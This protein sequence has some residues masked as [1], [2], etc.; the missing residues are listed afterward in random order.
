MQYKNLD[1]CIENKLGES[2]QVKANFE[3][4]EADGAFT[5]SPD[6][7]KVA[8]EL[9]NIEELEEGSDLPMSLGASL[10]QCLFRERVGEMLFMSLGNV[11]GGG[12]KEKDEDKEKGLRIRLMLSPPEVAALPWEVLYDQRRK[13]FLSTSGKTPLSRY[14]K[15]FEPIRALKI[16]PPVKVLILIPGGSGLDVDKEEG[17]ITEAL[18]DL[19][20]VQMRVIKDKVTRSEISRALVEEEYHILH[21]IGHGKFESDQ[22]YLAINGQTKQHDLVTADAFADFFRDYPSMKLVVLNACQGAEV[23]ATKELAGVAPQL[24]ARGIPAVVAMQYPIS[25]E[26]ALTF[27]REFYL[28][29]CHGSNR[30]QVDLA[31]S[32]ARNQIHMNIK[33]PLAFATPVLFLRSDAGVI[34][35]F[36]QN[37]RLWRRLLMLF[38]SA[39]VKN[40]GRLNEVKKTY[41]KNIAAWQEKAKDGSPEAL[42]EAAQAVA[43]ERAELVAI[44]DRIIRWQRTFFAS[45][46]ATVLIFLLGYVGLFNF[47]FH[48]DD[49]LETKSIPYMDEYVQKK[50]SPDVRLILADEGDNG[51]LGEPGPAWRKYHAQLIDALTAVKAKVIVFDLEVSQPTDDDADLAAAIKR[52]EAQGT[53]VVLGQALDEDGRPKNR[54]AE[55]LKN[56]VCDS[57]GNIDVGGARGGLVR[58]YQLAQPDRNSAPAGQATEAAVI[59][60][61]GLRAISRFLDEKDAVTKAVFNPDAE[62]VQILGPDGNAIK[63]I[64]VYKNKLSLYDFPYDLAERARLNDATESYQKVYEYVRRGELAYLRGY[65]G[66]LVVASFK[67]HDDSFNVLQGEP[68][69]GAEIH[70]N[71]ISNILS[72]VYVR[73]LP[74]AYDFLIVAL[75]AGFGALVRARFRHVFSAG[76]VLPLPGQKKRVDVPGLLFVADV[77]YLLVAFLLYKNELLFILKSYHL[78]APFIAYWLTGKMRSSATLKPG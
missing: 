16:T 72:N 23:A 62:Q 48:L 24:V 45:L 76:V 60:S 64:P 13:C 58:V 11:L 9:K 52:A 65:E 46:L 40:V 66:K 47:P 42:R 26:A 71:V 3:A 18:G 77:V 55:K 70:A 21:F 63:S 17:I 51:G 20:T 25:D 50:F 43:Q 67:Q 34:F 53:H 31:I 8:A 5:L 75:M 61:L 14:I 29:L 12:D 41:E 7:L 30:G 37:A 44:D 68:R 74:P 35:D 27:A 4:M 19:E 6:C 39:P 32:H 33:E 38:T 1:L 28:K 54:I 2:Y 59:P 22:G 73:L 69:Y 49:W 57:W 10:Y 15:L 36:E 56:S 78:A